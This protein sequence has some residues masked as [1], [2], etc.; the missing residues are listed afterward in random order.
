MNDPFIFRGKFSFSADAPISPGTLVPFELNSYWASY[1]PGRPWYHRR[2]YWSSYWQ[3]HARFATQIP[4]ERSARFGR[5]ETRTTESRT[6]VT[7]GR[8]RPGF[9][10]RVTREQ[11]FARG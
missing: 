11:G 7:E 5:T 6:A 8:T 10:Q 2:A 4:S 9:A 3:S 1:Y